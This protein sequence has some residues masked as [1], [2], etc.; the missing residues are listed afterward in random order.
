[1]IQLNDI[2]D[3]KVDFMQTDDEKIKK[4]IGSVNFEDPPESNLVVKKTIVKREAGSFGKFKDSTA[5]L[6][7]DK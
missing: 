7:R 4:F 1:M 2:V 5:V 3:G 6:T